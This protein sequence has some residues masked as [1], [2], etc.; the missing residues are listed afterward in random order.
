MLEPAGLVVVL[1][2]EDA[3]VEQHKDDD[4]PEHGLGLHRPATVPPGL[5]VPSLNLF[6]LPLKPVPSVRSLDCIIVLHMSFGILS[7][8]F[9]VFN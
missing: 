2:G 8:F 9:K 7:N 6:P 1:G 5:P 4:E 3:G